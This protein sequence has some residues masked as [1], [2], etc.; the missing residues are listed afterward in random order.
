MSNFDEKLADL[1]SVAMGED[2]QS[3]KDNMN[4]IFSPKSLYNKVQPMGRNKQF[5]QTSNFINSQKGASQ[6]TFISNSTYSN[7]Y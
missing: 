6:N 7:Y 1:S 4:M 2:A 5:N 3:S